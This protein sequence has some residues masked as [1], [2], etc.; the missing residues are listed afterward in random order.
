MP[1][2]DKDKG[3]T[4]TGGRGEPSSDNMTGGT[5]VLDTQQPPKPPWAF[6]FRPLWL[7][8]FRSEVHGSGTVSFG[9]GAS[10]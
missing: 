4:G 5:W 9:K 7:M 3:L 6:A 1:V 8:N 2:G 10:L